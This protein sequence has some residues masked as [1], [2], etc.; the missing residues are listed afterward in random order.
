MCAST[1]VPKLAKLSHRHRNLSSAASDGQGLGGKEKE[2]THCADENALYLEQE[3]T[4]QEHE[5]LKNHPAVLLECVH[6]TICKL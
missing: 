3:M 4:A 1:E 5:F 2:E 6:F